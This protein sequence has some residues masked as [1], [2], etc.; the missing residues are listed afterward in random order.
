MAE[1]SVKIA[2]RSGS[3]NSLNA[4]LPER[5]FALE[6]TLR[7]LH[8]TCPDTGR[9]LWADIDSD[10]A[11]A[12]E[13][14]NI[15]SVRTKPLQVQKP[16][17]FNKWKE[18]R[19]DKAVG[20]YDLDRNWTNN[21]SIGYGPSTSGFRG[22]VFLS[23][24]NKTAALSIKGTS[25]I[26]VGGGP[27]LAK[28]KLNDNLLFSCCCARVDW[29][30]S[31]VCG[32]FRGGGKCDQQC[33]EAQRLHLPSPPQVLHITHVYN[34]ADPIPMGTCTGRTSICYQ[35]GY[36]LETR[37]N[38]VA[39]RCH[40]GTT[41]VYDTLGLL[42]WSSG[43]RAHLINTV[44][45]KILDEDWSTK[46]RKSHK[47]RL[48]W[49]RYSSDLELDDEDKVIEV[50]A[51]TPETDCT[52]CFNWECM[53]RVLPGLSFANRTF[54]HFPSVFR[55]YWSY[56]KSGLVN[57]GCVIPGMLVQSNPNQ[58]GLLISLNPS[59]LKINGV[60]EV[61]RRELKR[62]RGKFVLSSGLQNDAIMGISRAIGASYARR[63]HFSDKARRSAVEH[64]RFSNKSMDRADIGKLSQ[65]SNAPIKVVRG[66]ICM[67]VS[68]AF[69]FPYKRANI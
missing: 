30:W 41:M 14:E 20:R 46:V 58:G 16:A 1:D 6:F 67:S 52:E 34:T 69:V 48:S 29:T 4:Q 13:T 18:W 55:D 2:D 8:H 39:F 17:S 22:H 66:I 12:S 56:H 59:A 31:P 23:A 68:R 49:L 53:N 44:I 63:G 19:N 42:H 10:A 50:S 47:S 57:R 27:T 33:V 25:A 62:V 51:P 26:I 5:V 21:H 38:S 36:A 43:V 60:A 35:A 3:R 15:Y 65:F 40:L 9:I 45:E 24:D 61:S 64:S 37:L 54:Q 28:D 11:V 7:H 32:C